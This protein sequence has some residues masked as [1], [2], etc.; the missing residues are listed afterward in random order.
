M[1][2]AQTLG[3]LGL[4]TLFDP[5]RSNLTNFIDEESQ[6]SERV[7]FN[8]YCIIF[9][10]TIKTLIIEKLSIRLYLS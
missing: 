6:G 5:L 8:R 3:Q 1:D 7:T 2:L 10:I 9:T 4:E